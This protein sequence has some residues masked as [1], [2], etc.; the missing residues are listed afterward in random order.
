ML[1]FLPILLVL[2][3]PTR[4]FA[5]EI[6]TT[7][8]ELK[9]P[10]W[11]GTSGAIISSRETLPL[12]LGTTAPVAQPIRFLVGPFG[13]TRA[14]E[15][16]GVGETWMQGPAAIG[17][18][19]G[20][21]PGTLLHVADVSATDG[22]GVHVD[23]RG[24]ATSTGIEV[25]SIG[26]TGSEHAGMVLSST[27]NGA[28]T[29]I[30]IGGPNGSGRATLQTSIDITGGTGVRY[31][32]LTSGQGTAL[33][34]GGTSAP[35]RGVDIHVSGSS[36][37]GVV[38]RAN[39]LGTGIIGGSASGSYD[40]APVLPNTGVFGWAASNANATADTVTGIFARALRG[41]S[42]SRGMISVA[43]RADATSQTTNH[44]GTAIGILA[45]AQAE[46]PGVAV[47][48][49]GLFRT[50]RNGIALAAA[51]GDV[52]LGARTEHV[53][54]PLASLSML[55][56]TLSTTHAFA[57]RTSGPRSRLGVRT[58]ILPQGATATLD[59]T[60]AEVVRVVCDAA[61][62]DLYGIAGA[63]AGRSLIIVN[64][65]G[66]LVLHDDGALAPEEERFLLPDNVDIVIPTD[67]AVQLWYDDIS[68]GW[69]ITGRSW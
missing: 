38:A 42:G 50:T 22:R 30:R 54:E 65:D 56:E 21:E 51:G 26:I 19:A 28:G 64:V 59:P 15:I 47:P 2:L 52:F 18:T 40:D 12:V 6:Q 13:S 7:R 49:A 35:Q 61:G 41:G 11:N 57:V 16:S 53:P 14:L 31:N 46:A 63:T 29:G 32:A 69:R 62:S 44:A 8:L 68:H 55:T 66:P 23:L 43:L 58:V 1:L 3:I 5:Q 10:A 4:V 45:D 67:G 25:S 27:V 20:T 48:I 34:V 17:S 37:V 9:G 60:D 36:S 39:T 33:E 24:T